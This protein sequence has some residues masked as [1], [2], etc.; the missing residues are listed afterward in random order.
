M[1]VEEL[2]AELQ[3]HEPDAVVGISAA[4]CRH[5]HPVSLVREPD[6]EAVEAADEVDVVIQAG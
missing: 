4:C 5:A 2:I 6:D 3:K 1:T